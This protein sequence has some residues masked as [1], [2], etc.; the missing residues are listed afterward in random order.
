MLKMLEAAAKI[1]MPT[2]DDFDVR[3]FL[4]GAIGIRKDGAMVCSKNGAVMDS[5][6]MD[7]WHSIAGSHAEARLVRK[8]GKGG[9]VFISRVARKDGCLAMAKPCSTCSNILKFAKV[10]KVIYSV[11]P[12]QYG[13]WIP[14][15]DKDFIYY[16]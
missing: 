3:S 4:L 7:N 14:K 5:T 16:F 11:N 10:K 1:A 6:S 8:L 2:N 12:L 15:I 9:V 13:V